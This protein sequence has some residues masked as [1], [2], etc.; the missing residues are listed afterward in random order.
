METNHN[1]QV[2]MLKKAAAAFEKLPE[3]FELLNVTIIGD[4]DD[5]HIGLHVSAYKPSD[6]FPELSD[7]DRDGLMRYATMAGIHMWL[8]RSQ[9]DTS[10]IVFDYWHALDENG[11]EIYQGIERRAE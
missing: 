9:N 3:S 2:E 1:R 5:R 6:V 4:D 10:A 11:T 8:E 7:I